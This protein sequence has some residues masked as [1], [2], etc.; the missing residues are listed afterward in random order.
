MGVKKNVYDCFIAFGGGSILD[1][2]KALSILSTN[3]GKCSDYVGWDL[4]KKKSTFKIAIPTLF[5]TG[6]EA[7]KTCVFIDYKKKIKMGINSVHS[8]YDVV[9]CDPRLQKT[10]KKD[11]FFY[12]AMDTY[13]HSME[14][15]DGNYRN[16]I[17]DEK[18][19]LAIKI[20]KEIF[21][22]PNLMSKKNLEKITIASFLG[23]S[24]IGSSFVGFVHPLSS[25]LSVNYKTKHCIA[26]CIIM[27]AMK[28]YY[29]KHFEEFH[30]FVKKHKINLPKV[31]TSSYNLD[32]MINSTIFHKKPLVNKFGI[33]FK[34]K[35][36]KKI[37]KEI[38]D[39]I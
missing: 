35:L 30:K 19:K 28:K 32:N 8:L 1:I 5:G 22:S 23:G 21:K 36:S 29:K 39:K 38:F 33:N 20:C 2:T 4:V 12:T 14:S 11:Q 27:K 31:H 13:I 37:F 10:L 17:A 9:I 34:K 6:A 16:F 25:A 3:S 18:S 7:S 24:A 26:N 15:L